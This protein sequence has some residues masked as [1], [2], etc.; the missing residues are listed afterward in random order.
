MLVLALEMQFLLNVYRLSIIRKSE[1]PKSKRYKSDPLH[2]TG[3][4]PISLDGS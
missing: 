1:N 4:G 3:V 2:I